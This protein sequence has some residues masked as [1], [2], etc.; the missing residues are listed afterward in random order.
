MKVNI[1]EMNLFLRK[2]DENDTKVLFDWANDS[3][4][5]NNSINQKM[6]MWENHIEWYNSKLKNIDTKIFILSDG[7]E[8][9]G[10][11]RIDKCKSHWEIDYSIAPEHRGK[12]LGKT[13]IKLLIE[14][15]QFYKFIAI[16]KKN[17]FASANVFLDLGFKKVETSDFN[18]FEY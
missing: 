11:V 4:V 1:K 3:E 17:N 2:A 10:Q 12:G 5:R 8:S 15:F 6:I 16:V 18:Y 7:N 14:K 9:F 13:I